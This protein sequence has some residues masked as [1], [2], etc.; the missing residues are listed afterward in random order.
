MTGSGTEEAVSALTRSD[1]VSYHDTWFKPNNA[2][3][4]VVGDTTLEEIE[5]KLEALF[6]RW[7]AG[8][9]PAKPLP[10]VPLPDSARIYL[11]DRPGA[12][13]SV[14]IAG[15]LVPKRNLSDDIAVDAMNDILGGAFTSRVNMN[16]REDKGWTYGADTAIVDTQAQRPFLAIAPVQ[17]DRTAESMQELKREIEEFIGSRTVTEA[18]VATSKRRSTLT[19]PGRWETS[20]AVA[21][22]I[23]ELVRFNLPDDYWDDYAELVSALD[24]SEVDAAAERLLHPERLTWIVVGDLDVIEDDVR[25][26]GFGD[27][28]IV[29]ADGNP[30]GAP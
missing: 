7:R 26:L 16:L 30:L 3:M 12:E 9:V 28:R 23:A 17:A 21:R 8:D 22:D 20:R 10:E 27:V 11:V 25:G 2:T 5:P 6:A 1:L 18:E 4:I 15:H 29:D 13:Q 14:V 24:A 19:L